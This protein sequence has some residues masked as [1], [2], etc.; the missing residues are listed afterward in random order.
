[1]TKADGD[2]VAML[3]VYWFRAKMMHELLHYLKDTVV[4]GD[5]RKLKGET[6]FEFETYLCFWLSALWVVVEGFNKLKLKDAR[7]QRLFKEHMP[8]LKA[9]RH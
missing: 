3:A 4:S 9:V 2:P 8:Y 1:M 7:V 6:W 5:L